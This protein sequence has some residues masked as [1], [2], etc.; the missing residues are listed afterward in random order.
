MLATVAAV[1]TVTVL[2]MGLGLETLTTP[3]AVLLW[4]ILMSALA[5]V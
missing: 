1:V 2:G 4:G 5:T 3:L